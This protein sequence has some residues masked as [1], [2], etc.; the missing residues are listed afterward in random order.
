M[1]LS[2]LGEFGL[3]EAL[4]RDLLYNPAGVITGAGDDA[5]VL[6]T[7][8]SAWLLFTTDMMVEGVHF[9]LEYSTFRQVGWKALAVNISDIAAMGGEPAHALVSLAVPPGL[10]SGGVL[11]LYDGLREAAKTYGVNIVGGDTVSSPD[12]LVINVALLGE[13]GPG[14]AVY[15]SGARP[16]DSVYV[17]GPLG[18]PAAGLYIFQNASRTFPPEIADYCRRAHTMPAPRVEAGIVLAA[19]GVSAMDDIS[20]GLAGEM[21]EICGASGTGCLIRSK[22]IPLDSRVRMIAREAGADP[23]EWA[24]YGGEDFELVF[25]VNPG[26]EKKV[27]RAAA[28]KGINVYRVGEIT[29]SREVLVEWRNG[30]ISGL[31]KRGYDHFR[32]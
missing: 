11:E 15:R 27:V 5:A 21:H 22:D 19:L 29:A 20:D 7:R 4:T 17:T 31:A 16:G 6:K 2:E 9:N 28:Q 32:K 1:K 24:L 12:R 14:M 25:T 26:A 3:I 23:L 30:E 18:A 13:V 10:D 8:G